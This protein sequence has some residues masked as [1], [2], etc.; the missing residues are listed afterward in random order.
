M[1]LSFSYYYLVDFPAV[2]KLTPLRGRKIINT[3]LYFPP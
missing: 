3:F 2:D 1:A